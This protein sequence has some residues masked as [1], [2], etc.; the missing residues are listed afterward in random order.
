[1]KTLFNMIFSAFAIIVLGFVITFVILS[2]SN[3]VSVSE[4]IIS[5]SV[6]QESDDELDREVTQAIKSTNDKIQETMQSVAISRQVDLPRF[7][8]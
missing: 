2:F 3:T 6:T 7:R 8:M 1:M 4:Q 5:T